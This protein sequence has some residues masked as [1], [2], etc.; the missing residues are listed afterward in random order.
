[1]LLFSFSE[2]T[3]GIFLSIAENCPV[4]SHSRPTIFHFDK[5][6]YKLRFHI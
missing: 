6:R 2:F 3:N 5:L 4:I 1:M